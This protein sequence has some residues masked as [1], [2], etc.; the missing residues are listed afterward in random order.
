[1]VPQAAPAAA[2]QFR[3][4]LFEPLQPHDV[5]LTFQEA[6]IGMVLTGVDAEGFEVHA[7][8]PSWPPSARAPWALGGGAGSSLCPRP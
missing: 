2:Q 6:R 3:G 1:M 8:P 7:R 5:D 4:S